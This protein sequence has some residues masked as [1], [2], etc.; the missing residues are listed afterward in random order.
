MKTY[1]FIKPTETENGERTYLAVTYAMIEKK[2]LADCYA[3][4]GQK[5][6]NNNAGDYFQLHT[7]EA[8]DVANAAL[9]QNEDIEPKDPDFI[10]KFT[11]S[12][13][14]TVSAYE[15]TA[16][17]DAI[18]EKFGDS[19]EHATLEQV[20]EE[21]IEYWDGRNW[22]TKYL[23]GEAPDYELVDDEELEVELNKA[24]HDMVATKEQGGFEYYESEKYFIHQSHWQGDFEIYQLTPRD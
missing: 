18:M 15:D 20:E 14:T 21:V 9:T 8:C 19:S 11:P 17:F 2:P 5:V 12:D 24:I 1:K 7:Q 6:G 10:V 4:Y 22:R 16:A 23:T 3:R 13:W